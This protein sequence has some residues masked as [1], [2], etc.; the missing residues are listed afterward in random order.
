MSAADPRS[1][2]TAP[3]DRTHWPPLR[4]LLQL[5]CGLLLAAVCGFGLT[6]GPLAVDVNAVR[7]MY[8]FFFGLP[9][10]LTSAGFLNGL[11]VAARG[12]RLTLLGVLAVMLAT[13]AYGVAV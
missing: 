8:I 11:C 1:W 12:R 3:A 2:W 4:W 10:G 9:T 7:V 5:I 13:L 6:Y